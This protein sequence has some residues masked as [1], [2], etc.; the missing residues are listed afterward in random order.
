MEELCPDAWLVNFYKSSRDGHRSCLCRYT[1]L[2]KVVRTMQC[3]NWDK[4]GDCQ[5]A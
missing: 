3:S 2:K 1:N 5:G 4:N